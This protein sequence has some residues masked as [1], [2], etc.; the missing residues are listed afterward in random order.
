M[1]FSTLPLADNLANGGD[2]T[3]ASCF[4]H[5]FVIGAH[6]DVEQ[7]PHSGLKNASPG[8]VVPHGLLHDHRNEFV[9]SLLIEGVV[10]LEA[11]AVPLVLAVDFV[12]VCLGDELRH[13]IGVVDALH[14]LVTDAAH[15]SILVEPGRQSSRLESSVHLCHPGMVVTTLGVPG[16][17]VSEEHMGPWGRQGV[18]G[19][20]GA[21]KLPRRWRTGGGLAEVFGD[22]VVAFT[23]CDING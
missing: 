13:A 3:V 20:E 22:V 10:E 16:P 18:R 8:A 4:E 9:S 6:V 12:P 1:I 23:K 19:A 17:G 14:H 21:N 2:K 7:V 5:S 15:H 11:A